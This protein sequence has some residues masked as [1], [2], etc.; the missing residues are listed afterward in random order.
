MLQLR[1]L[2]K[3]VI[4]LSLVVLVVISVI[5]GLYLI[6][7]AQ[8]PEILPLPLE[9]L[10]NSLGAASGYRTPAYFVIRDEDKWVEVWN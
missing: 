6:Q 9:L 8:P 10:T 2:G 4:L 7:L 1:R 5:S 3:I